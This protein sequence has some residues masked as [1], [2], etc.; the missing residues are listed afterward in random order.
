MITG[1]NYGTWMGLGAL[2]VSW[3]EVCALVLNENEW[4]AWI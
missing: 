2:N 1:N 4:D 3:D